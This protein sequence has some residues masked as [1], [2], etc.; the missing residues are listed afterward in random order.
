MPCLLYVPS[1]FDRKNE[2]S[3]SDIPLEEIAGAGVVNPE[4][5]ETL[6]KYEQLLK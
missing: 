3:T 2:D 1:R 6:T 5:G 4:T